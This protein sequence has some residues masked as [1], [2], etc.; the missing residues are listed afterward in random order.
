MK[1]VVAVILLFIML[2]GIV[3]MLA[4]AVKSEPARNAAKPKG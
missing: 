1:R 4:G 3:S 2:L